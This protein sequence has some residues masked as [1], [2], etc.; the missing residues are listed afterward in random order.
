MV[1]VLCINRGSSSLKYSLYEMG[2]KEHLLVQGETKSI[3]ALIEEESLSFDAVAHR[4]VHGGKEHIKPEKVTQGLI[5]KLKRI[6]SFAPLHLPEEIALVEEVQKHFPQTPQFLCFDTAFHRKMPMLSQHFPLPK[7]LFDEG[8]IRYGFHGLSYEYIT[9]VLPKEDQ[10][11]LI[12]AHLGNGASL[13][14]I[15]EGR[16][17]DTTMGFT[18]IGGVMMG[19]RSGDLDPGVLLYLQDEKKFDSHKFSELLNH[20]SGLLGVSG[21]SSDMKVLLEHQNEQAEFAIALFCQSVRK[22]IGAFATS[23]EGLKTLVFTAGIGE[24]AASVRER[25]CSGLSFLGIE[26]DREANKRGDELISKG[27]CRVLV[28]P[29]NEDLMLARHTYQLLREGHGSS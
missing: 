17:L 28:I 8:I 11:K 6:S 9:S 29:T 7:V 14:A 22:A 3:F 5:E 1:A 20:Q 25:V 27:K 10:E 4:I 18:P 21:I 12:I 16:P 19:S 26:I 13:A 23:L 24:K 2:E 15:L